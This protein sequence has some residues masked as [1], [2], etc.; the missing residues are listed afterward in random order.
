MLIWNQEDISYALVYKCRWKKLYFIF[1]EWRSC[2]ICW[3]SV[4]WTVLISWKKQLTFSTALKLNMYFKCFYYLIQV[5]RLICCHPF[6][7]SGG[8]ISLMV[9]CLSPPDLRR[10]L[11]RVPQEGHWAPREDQSDP[12]ADPRTKYLYTTHPR[13]RHGRGSTLWVYFHS[14]VFCLELNL[15]VPDLLH[16]W[17]SLFG[18]CHSDHYLLRDYHLIML[19]PPMRRG[20]SD[21]KVFLAARWR[22]VKSLP[23]KKN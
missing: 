17:I 13:D 2:S 11:F 16:V 22:T 5:W 4:S 7:H 10:G 8:L 3:T 19:F 20:K 6:S 23:Y 14:A 1:K 12:P 18:L 21:V 15:V 9:L